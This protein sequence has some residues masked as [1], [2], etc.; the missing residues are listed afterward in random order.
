MNP[1][2]TYLRPR[3]GLPPTRLVERVAWW[4]RRLG[5]NQAPKG[6]VRVSMLATAAVVSATVVYPALATNQSASPSHDL[7]TEHGGARA[8][9]LPL[10]GTEL[11]SETTTSVA[12]ITV[13]G[14]M[15]AV[16]FPTPLALPPIAT[17]NIVD[18]FVVSSR[19]SHSDSAAVTTARLGTAEVL[20]QT[21]DAVTVLVSADEVE[22]ILTAQSEG[23]IQ[24]VLVANQ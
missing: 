20:W 22:A 13:A 7:I 21:D 17:G 11:G 24:A 19:A 18:L 9:I 6:A 12:D 5:A 8:E 10:H 23:V 14:D 1:N 2:H 4:V 3:P 15:R 16:A